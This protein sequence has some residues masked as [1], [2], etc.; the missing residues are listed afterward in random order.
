MEDDKE[1][2]MRGGRLRINWRAIARV[3]ISEKERGFCERKIIENNKFEIIS[4][5]THNLPFFPIHIIHL[6]PT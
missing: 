3:E 6:L 4:S 2:Q 1:T 5:L